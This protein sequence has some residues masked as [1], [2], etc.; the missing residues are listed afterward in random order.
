MQDMLYVED[1]E[2]AA[3]LLKP[4]RLEILKQLGEPRSCLELAEIL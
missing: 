2:Q 3:T 4:Q 1:L